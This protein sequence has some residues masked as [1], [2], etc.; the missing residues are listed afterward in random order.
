MSGNLSTPRL[1]LIATCL[2]TCIVQSLLHELPIVFSPIIYWCD[3]ILVLSLIHNMSHCFNVFVANRLAEIREYTAV[4]SWR[5]CQTSI[6]PA[7]LGTHITSPKKVETFLHWSKGPEF[8]KFPEIEWP[9]QSKI[10]VQT[11]SINSSCF[12]KTEKPAAVN[13]LFISIIN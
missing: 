5:Y 9:T 12:T 7:N 2:S 8:L 11:F 3:S 13:D 1:E 6:N 10:S 4:S